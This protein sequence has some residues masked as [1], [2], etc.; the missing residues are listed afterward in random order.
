MYKHNTDICSQNLCC[1][2]KAIS[3]TYSVCVIH[4]LSYLAC[5]VHAPYYIVICC[6]SGCTI[7]FHIKLITAQFLE[8]KLLNVKCV[9]WVSLQICLK[10]FSFYKELSKILSHIYAHCHRKY[11]VFWSD[12]NETWIF[13]KFF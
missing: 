1:C 4:S 13:W 3:I 5:D 10:H 11:P 12:F 2:G 8:K 9:F 7:F 6:P